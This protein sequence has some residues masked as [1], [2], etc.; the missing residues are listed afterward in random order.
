M[1]G[2]ASKGLPVK[3]KSVAVAAATAA[4]LLVGPVSGAK[5]ITYTFNN[6]ALSDGG[7][8]NGTLDIQFGGVFGYSLT[9]TGGAAALDTVY[10]YPGFP[11]PNSIPFGNPTV[12]ELFP[13]APVS[14][15]F[16]SMLQLTFSSD[17]MVAGLH[18]LLGGTNGPSFE[19]NGSFS[20]PAG[21]SG[22]YP[23]RW[24]AGDTV[25]G[26]A[27]GN[28]NTATPLPAALPLFASGGGL[29]GFLGWRRKRKNAAA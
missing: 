23:I 18:T 28:D 8:L 5:A 24:I 25:I 7:L 13:A 26:L 15:Q 19:C 14:G 29:L 1:C 27:G 9:T 22:T 4:M 2:F 6:V 17:L 12:I 11:S 21:L 10:T 16:L 3:F 20:C